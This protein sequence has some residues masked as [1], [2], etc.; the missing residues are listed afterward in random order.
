MLEI[1]HL[2]L[3]EGHNFFGHHGAPAGDWPS[4]EVASIECVAGRGLRGDRFFDYKPDYKGQI[5]FFAMEVFESLRLELGQPNLPPSALR[6]NVLLRGQNLD[7]WIG[8][9]FELQDLRFFGTE[10]CRPCYWMDQA[11]QP[12]AEVWL[13]HRGGLRARI[14]SDGWLHR[15]KVPTP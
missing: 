1:E 10:A 3:S 7:A 9:E 12:G 6:R 5:T 8:T 13:K 14:L 11:I 15:T 2:F 4:R